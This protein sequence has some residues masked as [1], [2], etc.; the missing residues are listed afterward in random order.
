MRKSMTFGVAL[1]C[2]WLGT[3]PTRGLA[4][5]SAEERGHRL[6]ARHQNSITFFMHP[7][8]SF[9]S[10]SFEG[11]TTYNSGNYRLTYRYSFTSA[12]NNPFSS[13][14]HFNF[15]RDGDLDYIAIGP[16]TALVNPFT[17]ANQAINWA[18]QELLNDPDLRN[19][20]TLVRLIE[21]GNAQRLLEWMMKNLP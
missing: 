1:A 21:Q 17:A 13:T 5:S 10:R 9:N 6:I 12:F 11:R 8:A 3:W 7:T 20:E 18:K 2:C 15:T 14:L 4:Q 16:T 19:N